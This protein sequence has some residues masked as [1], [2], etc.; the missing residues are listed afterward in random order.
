M[1]TIYARSKNLYEFK[2]QTVFPAKFDKQNE[3]NQMFFET[4]FFISL[5]INQNI[6]ESGIDNIDFKSS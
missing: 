1:A 6:T 4:E 2:H 5:D 3:N